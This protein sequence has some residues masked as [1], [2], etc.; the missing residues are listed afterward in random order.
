MAMSIRANLQWTNVDMTLGDKNFISTLAESF[1]YHKCSVPLESMKAL[2]HCEH[3]GG[4]FH[5]KEAKKEV[6]D[7]RK[8]NK[9]RY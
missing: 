8:E 2:S 6:K 3:L 9:V 5:E 7:M 4:N 1:M